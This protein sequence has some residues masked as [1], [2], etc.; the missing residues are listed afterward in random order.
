MNRLSFRSLIYF[1]TRTRNKR[2][3]YIF[4]ISLTRRETVATY[5]Q[6][7]IFL[8]PSMV[9][10]SP[11]VL[12]ESLAS[13]TPFLVTDVGNAKEIISWTQGGKLLST[14]VDKHGLSHANIEES[15]KLLS[16]LLHDSVSISEMQT[17]GYSSW[18]KRFTWEEIASR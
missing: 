12:F 5:H 10:C 11:I 17:R 2:F 7:D 4:T 9:E 1:L 8:F 6:A 18:M 13:K 15:A 16:D 3:R 14:T